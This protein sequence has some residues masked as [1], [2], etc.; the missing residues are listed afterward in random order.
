M[1]PEPRPVTS[2]GG[3]LPY[4]D[5]AEAELLAL[6]RSVDDRRVGSDELAAA[7]RDWP[8]AYHLA[9][10]RAVLLAPLAISPD[11]RVL[12]V[13]A[14]SG[15][16]TRICADLGAAVTA[17]EA[18]AAR[19]ELIAHRC[20]GLGGVEVL[21]G[22]LEGLGADRRE[23]FDVVLLVGVLEYAGTS[24]GGG[25][26]PYAL[27]EQVVDALAPG[28]VVVLAIE[29]RLGLKYLLGFPEDHL[30]LP[31]A[32]L[33]GYRD[34]E[35]TT[36]SRRELAQMLADAGLAAQKWLYPFPDYKLP[37]A[38]LA[39]EIYHQPGGVDMVDQ[40]VGH[41]ASSEYSRPVLVADDRAAH[42]GLL[43]AGL[44]PDVAN[45]FLVVAGR[46]PD[47]VAERVDP[48]VLA[49]R[50]APDRR[51][52]WSQQAAVVNSNQGL[53]MRRRL[54][55]DDRAGDFEGWLGQV[56][57]GEEPYVVGRNLE[58]CLLERARQGD[59]DGIAGLLRA[60]RAELAAHETP[61][62][63]VSAPHPYLPADAARVLPPEW[64]DVG[65]D[66]FVVTADG[67]V[68]VDREW[69]AAGGVDARLAVVR[70]LWKAASAMLRA[71]CH[72]PWP[73]TWSNDRLVA[74]LGSL[75]GEDIEGELMEQWRQAEEDLIRRVYRQP[76]VRLAE[77][78]DAGNRSRMDLLGSPLAPYRRMEHLV[79]RQ[80]EL[81]AEL[82][83]PRQMSA[84]LEQAQARLARAEAE[85]G[86]QR[87][88]LAA[89]QARLARVAWRERIHNKIGG[90][91]R[92]S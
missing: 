31:W 19:A 63:S 30:G 80:Q 9:P 76:A 75:V 89:A 57:V 91:I 74:H 33:E 53:T 85:L 11:D 86:Q 84:D 92:R 17:V 2:I 42:I 27:L 73:V 7:I 40:L 26:G 16:N 36:W 78:H 88:E 67:L 60:W 68:F 13:G 15:V 1:G 48:A 61:V 81:I 51:R 66:N 65:P 34:G 29:N 50:V 55:A 90:L 56:E 77:L 6:F 59:G 44:G 4:A 38:V 70:G 41:P 72:L 39:E 18:S 12:D 21:C 14:G 3:S 69:V 58:Q 20:A 49:W 8:T 32:G 10:E 82:T 24:P 46:H 52:R 5:G 64:L 54:T 35:P 71:R 43:E 28:G 83:G 47:A 25:D 23:A 37:A 45:S 22:P 62:G 79:H 87:A